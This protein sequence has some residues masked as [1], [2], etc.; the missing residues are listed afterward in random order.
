[1]LISTLAISSEVKNLQPRESERDSNANTDTLQSRSE[2]D[3]IKLPTNNSTATTVAGL[4][5]QE[6]MEKGTISSQA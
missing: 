6:S 3:I 2:I 1:M 5:K 4:Y